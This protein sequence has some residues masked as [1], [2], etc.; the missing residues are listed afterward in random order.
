MGAA[1]QQATGIPTEVQEIRTGELL[2]RVEAE[3]QNPQW[4]LVW[5]D[6]ALAMQE[7]ADQH[8]LLSYA[9]KVNWSKYGTEN[10]TR[11]P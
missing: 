9:P 3:K 11:K 6:G 4:G 10:A 1:F 8:L 7:L 2:A 5:F